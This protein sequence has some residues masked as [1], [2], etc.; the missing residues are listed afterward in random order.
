[1]EILIPLTSNQI[2]KWKDKSHLTYS[3]TFKVIR[4]TQVLNKTC[5]WIWISDVISFPLKKDLE[6]DSTR[7]SIVNFEKRNGGGKVSVGFSTSF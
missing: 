3:K 2:K 6:G 5:L 7:F 1:M 4:K